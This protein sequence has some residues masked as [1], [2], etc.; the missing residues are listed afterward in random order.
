MLIPG[1]THF[2]WDKRLYREMLSQGFSMGFM[3]CI[4][5]SGTAILQSGIN[6]LGYLVI[7]GHRTEDPA[8]IFQ[9]DRTIWKN[10]VRGSFDTRISVYGSYLL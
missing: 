7:A 3:S 2:V 4:V 6:N 1:R 8:H 5:T 9:Y 10:S